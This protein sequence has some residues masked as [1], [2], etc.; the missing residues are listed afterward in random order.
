MI[1][2]QL[3]KHYELQIYV[4]YVARCDVDESTHADRHKLDELQCWS[5]PPSPLLR[6]SSLSGV[7]QFSELTVWLVGGYFGSF[8]LFFCFGQLCF[9]WAS[10]YFVRRGGLSIWLLTNL[11]TISTL[12]TVCGQH[13][14]YLSSLSLMIHE[15]V[16]FFD[17]LEKLKNSRL[18]RLACESA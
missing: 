14:L 13:V 7:E 2:N 8:H 15:L 12:T 16:P 4:I 10:D 18:K 17:V 3:V 5:V 11:S 6:S 9:V 1:T